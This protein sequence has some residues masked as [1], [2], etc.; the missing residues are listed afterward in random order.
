MKQEL[1]ERIEEFTSALID[2]KSAKV[3]VDPNSNSK[4]F[5][6]GGGNIIFHNAK[7]YLSGRYRDD[8]DSRTG[9]G[10]GERG[11]ELAIFS[12]DSV[13]GPW[14]KIKSFSK[15]DLTHGNENVVSIEGSSLLVTD[16][17]IDLFVS[18]EKDRPYPIDVIDFQK[19]GTGI[20]DID[21]ISASSV[22]ELKVDNIK[23]ALRTEELGSLHIKDPFAFSLD[24]NFEGVG[25]FFCSH[26]FTWASSNTGLAIKGAGEKEFTIK[27][28]NA[29][30]RGNSWDVAC[31]RVTDR[32]EIPK[33]GIMEDLPITLLYFYD[34]A[35]CL[36]SLDESPAAAK[37]PRGY[38]CEEIGGIGIGYEEEFP[39]INRFSEDFPL[40]ISP[41]GTGCSRYVSTHI[42]NEGVIA[43]WQQSQNDMSQPLVSNFLPMERIIQIFSS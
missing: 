39:L 20:W 4:G 19:K 18:T 6:F 26:P 28:F 14:E 1:K 17:G 31:A 3:I 5:W 37:R 36:R 11:L 35:E 24:H 42:T 10:A 23:R 43:T 13:D 25:L 27:S 2:Q 40:F 33:V 41:Y 16:S 30:G 9:V 22:E 15:L 21:F 34:G 12:S 7:Y 8:G 32:L 38:S 29:F